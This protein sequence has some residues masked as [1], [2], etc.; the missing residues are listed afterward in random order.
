MIENAELQLFSIELIFLILSFG[1]LQ[2]YFN[3]LQTVRI[4]TTSSP[5]E[6]FTTWINILLQYIRFSSFDEGIIVSSIFTKQL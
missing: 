5:L 4:T 2:E 1:N 3:W 6:F